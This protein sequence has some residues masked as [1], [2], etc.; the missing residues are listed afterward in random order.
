MTNEGGLRAGQAA[1][2]LGIA[3]TTLRTWDRRYGVGPE[4]RHPGGHRRYSQRDMQ[5]LELMCRLIADGV[6][7]ARAAQLAQSTT[8]PDRLSEPGPGPGP[9]ARPGAVRPPAASLRVRGLRRAALTLNDGQLERILSKAVNEDVTAAWTRLICPVMRDIGLRHE[10]TGQHV[11]TEHLLSRAASTAL[12]MTRRPDG[13]TTV[14]LACAG[15]EQHSLPLEALAAGLAERG[16]RSRMLGARVPT[17]ALT[18]AM[19]R[20]R[21]QAVVLWAHTPATASLAQL[22][23]VLTTRPRP[24]LVAAAGPGWSAASL[25]AGVPALTD[26]GDALDLLTEVARSWGAP[27]LEA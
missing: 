18:A 22:R 20:T 17:S 4:R 3:V 16:T 14:L 25:P 9:G 10:R 27:S 13:P 21:P 7:V 15:E 8:G 12:G 5:R 1:G 11:E 23:A 19:A 6:P 24:T 26:Y 2:Q